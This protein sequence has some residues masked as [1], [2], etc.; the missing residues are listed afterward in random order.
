MIRKVEAN[1]REP[2]GPSS[3]EG[4]K[5]LFFNLRIK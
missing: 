4:A 5:M 3:S 1:M 2:I